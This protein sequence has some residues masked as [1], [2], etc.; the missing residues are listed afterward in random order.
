MSRLLKPVSTIDPSGRSRSVIRCTLVTEEGIELGSN[1]AVLELA[2]GAT[3]P[4]QQ[5]GPVNGICP[6]V[7]PWMRAYATEVNK[8]LASARRKGRTANLQRIRPHGKP[9][10]SDGPEEIQQMRRLQNFL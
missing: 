5:E 8:R 9:H 1:S 2:D 4:L 10:P 6:P 7:S 3:V